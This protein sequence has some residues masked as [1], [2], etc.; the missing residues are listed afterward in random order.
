MRLVSSHESL[1]ISDQL[2]ESAVKTASSG[3]ARRA[4]RRRAAAPVCRPRAA[5][6]AP[7]RTARRPRASARPRSTWSARAASRR[8]AANARGRIANAT[9]PRIVGAAARERASRRRD[10]RSPRR[11]GTYALRADWNRRTRRADQGHGASA[12]AAA[13]S[14]ASTAIERVRAARCG[15]RRRAGAPCRARPLDVDRVRVHALLGRADRR[16]VLRRLGPVATPDR[17]PGRSRWSAASRS[18]PGVG[19]RGAAAGAGAAAR[20]AAAAAVTRRRGARRALGRGGLAAI[21]RGEHVAAVGVLV[22]LGRHV[23]AGVAHR[24]GGVVALED[25]VVVAVAQDLDRGLRVRGR[26]ERAAAPR[27]G[28]GR[29]SVASANSR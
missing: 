12:N 6:P 14:R 23:V 10:E 27:A 15:R 28:P 3:E 16:P 5:R 8:A 11:G 18:S 25:A 22:E 9:P 24:R 29:W 2:I 20:A 4:P 13:A 1:G 21:A 17:R 26:G 7:A 19:V